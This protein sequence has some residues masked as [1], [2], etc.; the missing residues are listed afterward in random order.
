MSR[1]MYMVNTVVW[2]FP[3]ARCLIWVVLEVFRQQICQKSY[4]STCTVYTCSLENMEQIYA[5]IFGPFMISC[6]T[7]YMSI[8]SI[9]WYYGS[10]WAI[11]TT[12]PYVTTSNYRLPV[13]WYY[14][15]GFAHS[16]PDAGSNYI[17]CWVIISSR[18]DWS[19][20]HVEMMITGFRTSSGG[21]I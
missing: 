2:T 1:N 20:D 7:P 15:N 3:N 12:A 11:P 8:H 21:I 17:P 14:I 13:F 16:A 6:I 9:L 5:E 4:L 19:R 10:V 18:Q